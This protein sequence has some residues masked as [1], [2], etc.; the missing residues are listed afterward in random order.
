MP[1]HQSRG[2]QP[3]LFDALP[4]IRMES[5]LHQV[6]VPA[7]AELIAAVLGARHP[8]RADDEEDTHDQP[9]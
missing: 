9:R 6:A 2:R 3:W 7:L 1:H 4:H 8:D 5:V